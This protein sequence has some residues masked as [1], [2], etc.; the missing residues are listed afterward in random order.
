MDPVIAQKMQPQPTAQTTQS[1]LDTPKVAD[2]QFNPQ[3]ISPDMYNNVPYM[4]NYVEYNSQQ[5]NTD[6]H[7]TS[8]LT[9]SVHPTSLPSTMHSMSAPVNAMQSVQSV[10][11]IDPSR[12][13]PLSKENLEK[14]NN[15]HSNK[16]T[17][18]KVKPDQNTV[19]KIL[20]LPLCTS[21]VTEPYTMWTESAK[22]MTTMKAIKLS[23]TKDNR[24][25][26]IH[27]MNLFHLHL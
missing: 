27:Q 12:V 20:L 10:Q 9:P 18:K 26:H 19:R 13:Q 17:Q 8:V 25:R 14:L 21:H 5:M 24:S 2:N 23:S 3:F 22:S 7:N 1:R 6:R 15:Q 11:A 4:P 16:P